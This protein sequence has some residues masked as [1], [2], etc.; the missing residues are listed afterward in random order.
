MT[1]GLVDGLIEHEGFKAVEEQVL[2]GFEVV[3]TVNLE[4]PQSSGSPERGK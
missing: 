1:R 2:E 3:R 4:G